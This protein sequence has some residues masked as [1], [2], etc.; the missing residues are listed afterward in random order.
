VN[1]KEYIASGILEAYALNDISARERLEVEENLRKY[2][3]LKAELDEI[4][5]SMELL[6]MRAGKV[7]SPAV[8][9]LVIDSAFGTSQPDEAIPIRPFIALSYWKYATAASL[10]IAVASS[11]LAIVF[12]SNW[13]RTETDLNERIALSQQMAEDYNTVNERLDKIESDM[14]VYDHPSF[15]KVILKGMETAPDAM[16]TVYWNPSSTEVYISLQNLKALSSN[17]QYQLWAIVDGKPVDM[18]MFDGN[19]AGL[20]KMKNTDKAVAFAVTV[21]PRGGKPT[22]TMESMMVMGKT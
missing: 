14:Q 6:L 19:V 12:W 18:G 22:P 13:K 11:V 2:P 16:A 21:E 5:R 8:R 20:I 7:P 15:K 17:L 4:E 3:E 1:Q 10:V 9:D